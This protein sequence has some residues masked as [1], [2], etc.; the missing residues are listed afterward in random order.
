MS[1]AYGAL[2]LTEP[3]VEDEAMDRTKHTGTHVP[4][5]APDEGQ[6]PNPRATVTA[7]DEAEHPAEALHSIWR[8][9]LVEY[10]SLLDEWSRK[11]RRNDP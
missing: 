9:R 7:P 3:L 6:E 2:K 11:A 1:T 8:A 10:F 4:E 5:R